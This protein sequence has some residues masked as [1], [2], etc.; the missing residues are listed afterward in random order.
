MNKTLSER[1]NPK[2]NWELKNDRTSGKN[3]ISL[4]RKNERIKEEK[5]RKSAR[6]LSKK[7]TDIEVFIPYKEFTKHTYRLFIF[8]YKSS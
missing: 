1:N 6:Y 2:V 4:K 3:F 5:R 7:L 8:K